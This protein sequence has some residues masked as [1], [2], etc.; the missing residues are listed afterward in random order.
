MLL[1]P[2]CG[3]FIS[4]VSSF[5]AFHCRIRNFTSAR[6]QIQSREIN[7]QKGGTTD[8]QSFIHNFRS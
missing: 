6:T 7:E 3:Y 4:V 2:F 5:I 8:K 1:V